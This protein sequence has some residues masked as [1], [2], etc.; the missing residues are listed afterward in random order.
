MDVFSAVSP[1]YIGGD[2]FSAVSPLYIGGDVFSAVSPLY[3]G[4]DVFSAVSPL[5]NGGDVFS[6]MSTAHIKSTD[7][8]G[9]DHSSWMRFNLHV[10]LN[11]TTLLFAVTGD[12]LKN[13]ITVSCSTRKRTGVLLNDK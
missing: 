1:L 6:A 10:K 9:A 5:Y 8:E 12:L 13:R 7:G 11:Q 4:G 3:I 2:D